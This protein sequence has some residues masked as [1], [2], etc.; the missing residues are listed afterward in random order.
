[1]AAG[2][3]SDSAEDVRYQMDRIEIADLVHTYALNIRD[4]NGQN[5]RDLFVDDAVFEMYDD[6]G[7]SRILRKKV[8][9]AAAIID[10]ILGSSGSTAR[11]CPMIHNLVI[12][13]E[14]D[15]AESRCTMTGVIIPGGSDFIGAYQDTLQW[16]GA[17]RFTKRAHTILLHRPPPQR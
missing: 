16:D 3:N 9:G 4:G 17:W 12:R 8:Q 2:R 7:G 15:R 10:Y 13:I 14:G 6:A 1:M 11:V 5:C